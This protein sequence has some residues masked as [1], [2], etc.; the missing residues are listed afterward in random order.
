[1]NSNRTQYLWFFR[2]F[3]FLIIALPIVMDMVWFEQVIVSLIYVPLTCLT[4]AL[5]AKVIDTHFASVL[6]QE[7]GKQ[8]RFRLLSFPTIK[9]KHRMM[10]GKK[11]N[12]A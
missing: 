11:R 12:A 9:R 1:M 6:L 3:A 4:L 7:Q 8:V 2:G 5:F 10:K